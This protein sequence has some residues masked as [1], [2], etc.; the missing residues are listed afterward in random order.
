MDLKTRAAGHANDQRGCQKIAWGSCKQGARVIHSFSAP[1]KSVSKRLSMTSR[2]TKQTLM[3]ESTTQIAETVMQKVDEIIQQM[4]KP[5]NEQ[6][7][8]RLLTLA[9][10]NGRLN[11]LET[12]KKVLTT[13]KA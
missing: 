5:K 3:N 13:G 4:G 12:G 8:R 6:D 1:K 11:G 9:W 7:L 10:L 2:K